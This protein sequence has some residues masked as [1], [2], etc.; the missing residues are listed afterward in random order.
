MCSNGERCQAGALPAPSPAIPD[1]ATP[2][3][4][5]RMVCIF[6]VGGPLR[7]SCA[8]GPSLGI[9]ENEGPKPEGG[10]EIFLN[11]VQESIPC[12]PDRS[13]GGK[14]EPDLLRKSGSKRHWKKG[15]VNRTLGAFLQPRRVFLDSQ[16]R[17]AQSWIARRAL[18]V[19]LYQYSG[20]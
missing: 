13:S 4:G 12:W 7:F 20:L 5:S 18:S 19:R 10:L 3:A 15:L 1:A 8:S 11:R 14:G 6:L 17:G 16:K 9:C 2:P